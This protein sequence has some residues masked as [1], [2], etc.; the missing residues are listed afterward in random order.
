[1]QHLLQ[2]Q[3]IL[4]RYDPN[5]EVPPVVDDLSFLLEPGE[6]GC[7]LGSSGCGK[8]TVLRSI[9]GFHPLEA[10]S[11]TLNGKILSSR[12]IHLAPET[13]H[14][15]M[16]F[17]DYALFPHLS[18]CQNITFGLHKMSA[19]AREVVCEELLD[20]VQ[21]KGFGNRY[22]HELSGGQQQRVA[23]AR[24]LAPSPSLLL[25]DEPL[26]SLDTELRRGLALEVREILKKRGISAIMVTH[27]Q[28]EA[29][30]FADKIG[31]LHKGKLEQWDV[32]FSL[33]HEPKTRYV[34]GFI[35]QGVFIPGFVRD[36]STIETELGLLQSPKQYPWLPNTAVEVLLRPDDITE[37]QNS[38]Y[39]ATV[40][41]KLFA[42]T[43]TLY[44]LLLPTGSHIE[45]ALPSHNDF[46]IGHQI[47][48]KV[49]ADHLIAFA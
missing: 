13:R 4:C 9:A 42:G 28:D 35:G 44:T 23:L 6:I 10:G 3:N 48:I 17:Q 37:S 36:A 14:I 30:A 41:R 29:F 24:A 20:L 43:S 5:P 39:Q 21:L 34:A 27:D 22:P 33:Y 49:D 47:N 2:V 26:S 18:V 7:L 25:L 46:A 45:A 15:G 31:V 16:V 11:I 38:P 19:R 8:T 40:I 12:S 32:P 1:M